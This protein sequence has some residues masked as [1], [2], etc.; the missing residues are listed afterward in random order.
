MGDD[1]EITNIFHD[2]F[3]TMAISITGFRFKT[4]L[5]GMPWHGLQPAYMPFNDKGALGALVIKPNSSD[6]TANSK[7]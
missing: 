1:G 2:V 5:S 6:F 4:W 3:L 7:Y